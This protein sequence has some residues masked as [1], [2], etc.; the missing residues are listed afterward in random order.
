MAAIAGFTEALTR[1]VKTPVFCPETLRP[2]TNRLIECAASLD[3][4]VFRG[5]LQDRL[6]NTAAF[7]VDGCDSITLLAGLDLMG[8]CA[9]SGSACSAGSVEPSHVLLAMGVGKNPANSLVRFSLGRDS[10]LEEVETVASALRHV[11]NQAR[12]P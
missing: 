8:I 4:V 5:S 3:G 7:T 1:F 10:T 12:F 2:L 11:V 6:A 9:S